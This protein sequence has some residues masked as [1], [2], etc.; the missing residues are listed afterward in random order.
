MGIS[1]N[2]VFYSV[3]IR[4]RC[5]FPMGMKFQGNFVNGDDFFANFPRGQ[6]SP[7]GSVKRGCENGNYTAVLPEVDFFILYFSSSYLKLF[8]K[9]FM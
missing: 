2:V 9:I 8:Q 3:G 5:I 1:K 4:A 7:T 6:G